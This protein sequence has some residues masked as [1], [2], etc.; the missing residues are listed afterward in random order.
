V[1]QIRGARSEQLADLLGHA[2]HE[3]VIHR[4]NLVVTPQRKD[5][6]ER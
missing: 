3:T 1:A 5:N 6:D 2:S 4:D